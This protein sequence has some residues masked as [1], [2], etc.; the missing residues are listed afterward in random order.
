MR[1]AALAAL[2]AAP[3]MAAPSLPEVMDEIDT[4][5]LEGRSMPVDYLLR[6]RTLREPADRMS[7]LIYLRRAGLLRGP[8]VSLDNNVFIAQEARDD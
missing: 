5:V 4:F 8:V 7:A 1:W 2:I 6:L 3:A